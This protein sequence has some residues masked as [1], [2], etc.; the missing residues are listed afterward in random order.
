MNGR[1]TS[2]PPL[3]RLSSCLL[4]VALGEGADIDGALGDFVDALAG[5]THEGMGQ[6]LVDPFQRNA[7][8]GAAIAVERA[9]LDGQPL[10]GAARDSRD[11]LDRRVEH[12]AQRR[13]V[14]V[15]AG[16]LAGRAEDELLAVHHLVPGLRTPFGAI[17]VAD[18]VIRRDDADPGIF[19]EIE[20]DLVRLHDRLGD[21]AGIEDGHDRAVLRRGQ[22]EIAHR[23]QAPGPRHVL[24]DDGRIAGNVIA[25]IARQARAHNCRSRRPARSRPR[26]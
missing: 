15:V 5:E 9:L 2:S 7:A 3:S 6:A 11:L 23:R 19:A 17:A 14:D 12:L 1:P 8:V 26:W 25:D 24:H 16:G 10:L 4:L 22:V 21:Q 13:A 18:P 20:I